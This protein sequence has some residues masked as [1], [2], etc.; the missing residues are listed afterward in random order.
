MKIT[1]W[2]IL[3]AANGQLG[4]CFFVFSRLEIRTIWLYD[5]LLII[6]T[7]IVYWRS[8]A[9]DI[10]VYEIFFKQTDWMKDWSIF[11][12]YQKFLDGTQEREIH[13]FG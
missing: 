10:F 11:K 3:A 1:K 12:D 13:I 4:K 6:K 9:T 8:N 2:M 5:R 7:I